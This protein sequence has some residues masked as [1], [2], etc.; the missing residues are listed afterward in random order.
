VTKST[1]TKSALIRRIN[2][3]L[4]DEGVSVRASRG[5]DLR[6]FGDYYLANGRPGFTQVYDGDV[7]LDAKGRE[8]GVLGAHE[9][10]ADYEHA[11]YDSR[12]LRKGSVRLR[13][14]LA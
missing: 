11:P 12:D 4:A 3:K 6:T 7:N 13:S 2:R 8:L 5:D 14:P 10:V 9:A 1:V